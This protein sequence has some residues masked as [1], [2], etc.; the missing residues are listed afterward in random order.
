MSDRFEQ[1]DPVALLEECRKLERRINNPIT[2]NFLEGVRIEAAHQIGRWGVAHDRGKT[3]LDWFWLIG[4]L[5]QKAAY[6]DD[7]GNYK[8]ALHHTISTAAAMLNWH[9]SILGDP[10]AQLMRPGIAPPT[11]EDE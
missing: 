1:M 4:F 9:S 2:D 8:K 5:A 6:A 7:H 11:P 3:S 10:D